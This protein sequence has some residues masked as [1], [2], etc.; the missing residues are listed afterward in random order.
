MAKFVFSEV[1]NRFPSF[2]EVVKPVWTSVNNELTI[3]LRLPIVAIHGE[4]RDMQVLFKAHID[5]EAPN[6][7]ILKQMSKAFHHQDAEEFFER[8]FPDHVYKLD[9]L[10]AKVLKWKSEV[11][12][13]PFIHEGDEHLLVDEETNFCGNFK[14]EGKQ[15]VRV[16]SIPEEIDEEENVLTLEGTDDMLYY[17]SFI[18]IEAY[19]NE[20]AR[21]RKCQPISMELDI[22]GTGYLKG[23]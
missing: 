20:I 10:W 17:K 14:I 16:F 12:V 18:G 6:K 8:F 1:W 3:G 13:E 9:K 15:Y 4:R 5:I 19:N 23:E 22:I 2:L 7:E 21:L 11:E